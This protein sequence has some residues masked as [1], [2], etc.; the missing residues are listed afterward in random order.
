MK[1]NLAAFVTLIRKCED[2]KKREISFRQNLNQANI[3]ASSFSPEKIFIS[4]IAKSILSSTILRISCLKFAHCY[5][6]N[7]RYAKPLPR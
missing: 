4:A 7:F 6:Y 3:L 5:N 2:Q 1:K